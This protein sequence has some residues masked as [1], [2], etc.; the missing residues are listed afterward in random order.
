MD[1]T[2][3]GLSSKSDKKRRKLF[4]RLENDPDRI[5]SKAKIAYRKKRWKESLDCL[6]LLLDGGIVDSDEEL[7]VDRQKVGSSKVQRKKDIGSIL[8]KREAKN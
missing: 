1:R 6:D 8:C 2:A 4:A 7:E 3:G 5:R